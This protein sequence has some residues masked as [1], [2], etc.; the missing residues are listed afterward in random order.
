MQGM[1][2]ISS[3][4]HVL[5]HGVRRFGAN[6]EQIESNYSLRYATT[7]LGIVMASIGLQIN[8]CLVCV[9]VGPV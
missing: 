5:L 8:S 9:I 3:I 2:Q 7:L 6:R 4:L 1:V